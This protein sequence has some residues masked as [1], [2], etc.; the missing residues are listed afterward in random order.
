MV[1]ILVI[2]GSDSS[3]GAGI[4]ADV[5]T[6][7]ALNA[8]GLTVLT[9]LTAQNSQGVKAVHR[10]PAGFIAHQL[11]TVLGD[12]KPDAVKVGMLYYPG[13]VRAVMGIV[14]KY[15][16]KN[17]VVDPVLRAS[18]GEMLTEMQEASFYNQFVIPKAD[19]VT[20]N[21]YEAEFLSGAPV[22]DMDG[23]VRAAT[24]IKAMG[25]DVVVTG[26]HLE[27]DCIDLLYDGER[28]Y[29]LSSPKIRTPHTHG[30]GCVFSTALATFLAKGEGLVKAAG[31][32]HDYTRAAI[33]H[34]YECG[35]GAG[36]VF[37]GKSFQ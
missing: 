10:V 27:G 1:T 17:V 15:R 6:V 8:H 22:E 18:T 12:V 32:A 16:L 28:F 30:S 20:P 36:P 33:A 11:D 2:A 23:M 9:A 26:G 37:S 3:G 21:L 7:A 29:R 19:V 24:L 25:P 35:K 5:K 13:A 34:G 14:E 4:Q 31:L